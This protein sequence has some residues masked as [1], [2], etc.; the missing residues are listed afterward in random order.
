MSAL[1]KD[2]LEVK[3][4]KLHCTLAEDEKVSIL[5]EQFERFIRQNTT[6]V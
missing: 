2:A 1:K 3:Q 5:V 6:D 4:L